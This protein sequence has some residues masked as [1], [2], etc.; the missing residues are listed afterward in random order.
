MA[1]NR[2]LGCIGN[3]A[4]A[5]SL[6]TL[7]VWIGPTTQAQAPEGPARHASQSG[8]VDWRSHN[9]DL[10]NGHYS[11][12]DD[13]NVPNVARL[14]LKWSFGVDAE[15]I[16]TQVT[17]L[18][19]D[20]IMYFNAGSKLF[21]INAFTG[22][23]LWTSELQPAFR[24]SSIGRRGPTY[25]D[26]RIYVYGET[27]LHAVDAKT[28]TVVESFGDRGGLAV[29]AAAVRFKYTDRVP[30]GYQIASPPTFYNGTLYMGLAQSERHIQDGLVTAIDGATGAIKWVF[31]TVPQRPRDDG[32]EMAGD[33]W[34]GG[35][36]NGG[37]VWYPP[38]IDPD[39]EMLYV[40]VANPDPAYEGTARKGINL[41]T[42]SIV[43]LNLHTGKL[44]WH[45]QTVHHDIWDLDLVTGPL[46]FDVPA[47]GRLIKGVA[48]AGKKLLLIS[49]PPRERTRTAHQ[50]DR[51]NGRAN[52]DRRPGRGTVANAALPVHVEGRSDAAVLCDVS[53]D[54]GSG[55]RQARPAILHAVLDQGAL[56]RL[57][58]RLQLGLALL[59]PADWAV[60]REREEWGCFAHGQD[61]GQQLARRRQ[62][63]RGDD[64][65][66]RS[67]HGFHPE[68]DCDGL[69]SR[70]RR[71]GLAGRASDD[72]AHL[73]VGEPRDRWGPG[74]SRQR[75]RRLLRLGRAYRQEG[76]HVH[77]S[78]AGQIE[79]SYLSHRRL[80]V[81]QRGGGRSG[82]DVWFAIGYL[83]PTP[84][85]R[86][87]VD[88]EE[89]EI[90]H[91][92]Q[93]LTRD[94]GFCRPG[95]LRTSCRCSRLIIKRQRQHPA[96]ERGRGGA[97][98]SADNR[99]V[100][101]A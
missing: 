12:V 52:Q 94:P 47:G 24:G 76:V 67:E 85:G 89:G 73:Y 30:L 41:F 43:A 17:P 42:N 22:Q 92:P 80:A 84:A 19:V 36:R 78:R 79:S 48:T 37:G 88:G 1:L 33:T 58:R 101:R 3:I 97:D 60:L 8:N 56:R 54:L 45:Y 91:P 7:A 25:G 74:V 83:Y 86:G 23:S 77:R 93:R 44:A 50:S 31:N 5:C 11:H 57:P 9:F 38:A 68:P 59:Q 65:A 16:I 40:N 13:I 71:S 64:G 70:H 75:H 35:A 82:A 34:I 32:W 62:W 66:T 72:D 55:D 90:R 26:G 63:L 21:A 49:V 51:R 15:D 39:L 98:A 46:L 2:A 20:G 87:H 61:H 27:I 99:R 4:A 29:A 81:C 10:S 18:V 100:C 6:A 28:G 14:T 95:R 53:D 96:A 69:Q